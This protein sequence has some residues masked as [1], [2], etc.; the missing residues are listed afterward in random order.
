M[1]F[2]KPLD[3][4]APDWVQCLAWLRQDPKIQTPLMQLPDHTPL[5]ARSSLN[6]LTTNCRSTEKKEEDNRREVERNPRNLC[7]H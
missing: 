7:R 5:S 6:L 1:S 3:N 4:T 2:N